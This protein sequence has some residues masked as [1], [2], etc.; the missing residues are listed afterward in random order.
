MEGKV[1]P[2]ITPDRT[3]ENWKTLGTVLFGFMTALIFVVLQ[4]ATMTFIV[5]SRKPELTAPQLQ[6]MLLAAQSDGFVISLTT[7][8]TMI[9]CCAIVAG[10]IKLKRGSNLADY[11]AIKSVP[12]RALI[13]WLGILIAL[14]AASD[15]VSLYLGRP[16]VPSFMTSTY[17]TAQPVWLLWVALVFA[18]P[19]FEE[20]FFRGFLYKGFASGFIGPMGSVILI[21]G[22]WAAIH[23]QYD[24]YDMGTI[25]ITGVALGLARM[26]TGSLLV[27]LAMHATANIVANAE[28]A[29]LSWY[30]VT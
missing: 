18:A 24:A 29:I 25:F 1:I 15:L 5:V 19:V 7:I 2:A 3:Y 30:S 17:A 16:L 10:V 26:R 4:M 20:I 8:V 11:L 27:P 22:L 14:I 28:V 13:A 23:T 9:V 21:A 12:T 6:D